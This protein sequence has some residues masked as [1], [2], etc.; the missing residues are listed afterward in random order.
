V[1]RDTFCIIGGNLLNWGDKWGLSVALCIAYT[2][3][4]AAEFGKSAHLLLPCRSV[5]TCLDLLG[6]LF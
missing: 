3:T 1:E 6:H 4:P 2:R 5:G